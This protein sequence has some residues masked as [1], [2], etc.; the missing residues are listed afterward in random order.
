MWTPHSQL[1][2][3]PLPLQ[4][5]VTSTTTTSSSAPRF[6]TVIEE[7][8]RAIGRAIGPRQRRKRQR[9]NAANQQSSTGAAIEESPSLN[10][11][12]MLLVFVGFVLYVLALRSPNSL[13]LPNKH[14]PPAV[15]LAMTLALAFWPL[16]LAP[17]WKD[18]AQRLA[19]FRALGRL[20][21]SPIFAVPFSATFIADVLTSMPKIFV[22]ILSMGCRYANGSAFSIHYSPSKG[23]LVGFHG[24]ECTTA[25]ASFWWMHFLLSILPFWIRLMQCA[26]PPCTHARRRPLSCLWL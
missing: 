22:D 6:G 24:D 13:F 8:C 2:P 20:L 14:V 10:L 26:G 4:E 17:E 3:Q 21:L 9:N 23:A 11:R 7:P 15:V 16:N 12:R 18:K 5:S 19:L 1:A 25:S